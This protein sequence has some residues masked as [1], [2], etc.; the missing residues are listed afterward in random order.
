MNEEKL[1]LDDYTDLY[2]RLQSPSADKTLAGQ[3]KEGRFLAM[4]RY[5]SHLRRLVGEEAA[6]RQF[7]QAKADEPVADVKEVEL[8]DV[9]YYNQA[10]SPS[11]AT[12]LL[13]AHASDI[14]LYTNGELDPRAFKYDTWLTRFFDNDCITLQSSTINSTK[15][16]KDPTWNR[17]MKEFIDFFIHVKQKE[18]CKKEEEKRRHLCAIPFLCVLLRRRTNER[19][20]VW[21]M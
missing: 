8:S 18:Y 11:G 16:V 20:N 15:G 7:E 12:S 19:K 2:R 21:K 3:A 13:L 4:A 14:A 6:S 17:T 10:C 5:Y 9:V 1:L